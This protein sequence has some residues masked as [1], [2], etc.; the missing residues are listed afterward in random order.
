MIVSPAAN[1][2]APAG[3]LSDEIGF[4]I[5]NPSEDEK[6]GLD[7]EPVEQVQC[8]KRVLFKSRFKPVPLITLNQSIESA[9]VKIVLQQDC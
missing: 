4:F 5:S 6:C 9:H 3:Y 8:F 2:M 1:L 7:L